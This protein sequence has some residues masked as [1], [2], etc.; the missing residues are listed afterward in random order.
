MTDIWLMLISVTLT[1][2]QGHSGLAEGGKISV[3][4]SRQLKQA[5]QGYIMFHVAVT[6]NVQN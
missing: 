4:L 6:L 3:E 1:L 2:M 5:M